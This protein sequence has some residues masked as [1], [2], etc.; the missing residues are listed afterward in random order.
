MVF[1]LNEL[2]FSSKTL[3]VIN[4]AFLQKILG[5]NSCQQRTFVA[6]IQTSRRTK[7]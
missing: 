4:L 2:Q 7:V 1:S 5:K 6:E 3:A